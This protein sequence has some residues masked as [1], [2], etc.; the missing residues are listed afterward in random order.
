MNVLVLDVET[1]TINKGNPFTKD[2]KLCQVGVLSNSHYNLYDIEYSEHPYGAY[3]NGIQEEINNATLLIGFNIKFDLHWLRRYGITFDSC[4][5]WDCQI[6]HFL[7][8]RQQARYPSLDDVAEYYELGQKIDKIKEY[9]DEGIDTPDIPYDEL[10]DYLKQD[11]ALT[12]KV[13]LKQKEYFASNPA[14]YRLFFLEMLDLPILQEME[15]NGMRFDK[16]KSLL[17]AKETHSR[18]VEI[19]NEIFRVIREAKTNSYN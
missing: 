19:K 10:S 8:T 9:W 1:T 7:I 14:L 4:H 3:L 6:A 12:Y 15:W 11:L 17:Q 2:N 5:I 18:L 13:Y 16:E